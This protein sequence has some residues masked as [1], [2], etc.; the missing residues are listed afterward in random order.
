[1]ATDYLENKFPNYVLT[2]DTS[3]VSLKNYYRKSGEVYQRVRNAAATDNPQVEGWYQRELQHNREY[4]Y[5]VQ[6]YQVNNIARICQLLISYLDKFPKWNLSRDA[7]GIDWKS[8]LLDTRWDDLIGDYPTQNFT[9]PFE[10]NLFMSQ[11]LPVLVNAIVSN[12]GLSEEIEAFDA[13]LSYLP[14][15]YTAKTYSEFGYHFNAGTLGDVT[16]PPDVYT[17]VGL[18]AE[19]DWRRTRML[20]QDQMRHESEDLK[21]SFQRI[22]AYMDRCARTIV[23]VAKLSQSIEVIQ[24]DEFLVKAVQ[25]PNNVNIDGTVYYRLCFRNQLVSNKIYGHAYATSTGMIKIFK[26]HPVENPIAKFAAL[27]LPTFDTSLYPPG[28]EQVPLDDV[29]FG[30]IWFTTVPFDGLS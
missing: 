28:Y 2:K 6:S 7:G 24:P 11:H 19:I 25:V 16:R 22:L 3:V 27:D 5:H 29:Q 8:S 15:I 1:M 21:Q 20:I 14:P 13:V 30:K 18:W 26:F 10:V 12:A 4:H 17:C 9:V 23:E